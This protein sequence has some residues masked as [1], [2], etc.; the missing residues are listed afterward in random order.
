MTF[1][2]LLLS[3][4]RELSWDATFQFWEML[5]ASERCVGVPLLPYC[6]ASLFMSNRVTLL[7]VGCPLLYCEVMYSCPTGL[8]CTR[9]AA[10]SCMCSNVFMSN[11]L[12]C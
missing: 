12:F 1:Q 7:K 9:W 5:W 11:R 8:P 2:M 10:R 4:R 6:V 3:L